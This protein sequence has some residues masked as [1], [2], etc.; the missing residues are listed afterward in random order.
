MLFYHRGNYRPRAEL[1]TTLME[2]YDHLEQSWHVISAEERSLC[3]SSWDMMSEFESVQSCTSNIPSYKEAI[4]TFT[5]TKSIPQRNN[6]P[7]TIIPRNSKRQD[8]DDD[9]EVL[10]SI[11]TK[12]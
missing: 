11:S 1:G 10:Y 12:E 7:K 8:D 6:V 3:S 9:N 4:M 2:E 5:A